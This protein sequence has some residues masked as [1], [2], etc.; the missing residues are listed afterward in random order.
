MKTYR[1]LIV[2]QKAMNFV[3]EVYQ[4][5]KAFPKEE[6]FGI[7][8]QMRRCAISI[9][10]NIAEGYGRRSTADYQR[11]L[12]IAIGSLYEIQTQL[13]IS[14][15]LKYMDRNRFVTVNELSREIERMLTSLAR[16]IGG[17]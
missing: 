8:S 7:I 17:V 4:T 3:T 6:M 10:S 12:Q 11:F 2:W 16:K 5:T 14:F 9:P 1:D 15:N 13:E